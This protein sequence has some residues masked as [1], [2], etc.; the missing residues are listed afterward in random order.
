MI[1][2]KIVLC[3]N[4]ECQEILFSGTVEK[5]NRTKGYEHSFQ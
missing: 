5:K 1:D 2:K 4:F 3:W